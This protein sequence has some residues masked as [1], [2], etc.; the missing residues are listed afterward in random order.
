MCRS[1]NTGGPPLGV[2]CEATRSSTHHFR[3]SML[4][5]DL[6]GSFLRLR[7]SQKVNGM[8]D[9]EIEAEVEARVK[10]SVDSQ[11]RSIGWAL[12]VVALVLVVA[13]TCILIFIAPK[14]GDMFVEMD[15]GELPVLTLFLLAICGRYFTP[16]CVVLLASAAVVCHVYRFR[17]IRLV[18]IV[19]LVL[20]FLL[21]FVALSM[22]FVKITGH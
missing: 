20:G 2:G 12:T 13:H 8:T 11:E 10:R 17:T 14:F 6:G 1:D 19:I 21:E 16:F 7:L 4:T 3:I 22:P 15:V 5:V 18:L 9:D